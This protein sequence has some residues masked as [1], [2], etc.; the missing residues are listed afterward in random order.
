M[1]RLGLGSKCMNT[2]GL[3]VREEAT[4]NHERE[5]GDGGPGVS[6]V[7]GGEL[8]LSEVAGEHDGN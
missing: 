1:S 3:Q 7:R 5:S 8:S 6:E 2:F 4:T